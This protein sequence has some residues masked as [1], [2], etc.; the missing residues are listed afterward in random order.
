M[1][2]PIEPRTRLLGVTTL[3]EGDVMIRTVQT[4]EDPETPLIQIVHLEG[5]CECAEVAHATSRSKRMERIE[6][7][8]KL[9][10]V[11]MDRKESKMREKKKAQKKFLRENRPVFLEMLGIVR[12]LRGVLDDRL[13]EEKRIA[14]RK[15]KFQAAV[16]VDSTEKK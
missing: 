4:L 5:A 15:N 11:E 14:K 3:D 10:A 2:S 8:Q 1:N 12:E 9:Y 6:R 13:A 16:A 7:Y